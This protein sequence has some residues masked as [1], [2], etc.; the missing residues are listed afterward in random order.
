M[1]RV[2][3]GVRGSAGMNG[4]LPAGGRE[5]LCHGMAGGQGEGGKTGG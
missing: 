4:V 2:E 3:D 1:S 5:W